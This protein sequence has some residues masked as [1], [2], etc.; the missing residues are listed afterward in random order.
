MFYTRSSV[1]GFLSIGSAALAAVGPEVY[2]A[3]SIT[4]ASG[5]VR[6]SY[7]DD[8]EGGMPIWIPESGSF[9]AWASRAR[10]WGVFTTPASS[11]DNEL[12][13]VLVKGGTVG[14]RTTVAE[15]SEIGLGDV[16]CD[17]RRGRRPS[18]SAGRHL[19]RSISPS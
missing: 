15:S 10:R 6:A 11:S 4:D 1:N 17:S 9:R 7:I 19:A 16:R 14:T 2:G 13:F 12:G 8:L 3:W 18:P 5:T